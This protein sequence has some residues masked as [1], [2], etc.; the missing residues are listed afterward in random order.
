[1]RVSV[2]G[3]DTVLQLRGLVS[4]LSDFWA[5]LMVVVTLQVEGERGR[6]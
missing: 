1:L 5:P 4:D 6:R 3:A 2:S